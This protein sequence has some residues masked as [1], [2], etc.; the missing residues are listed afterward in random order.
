MKCDRCNAQIEPG[1]KKEYLGQILCEDCYMDAL[2]PPKGCDPWAV[3]AAKSFEKHSASPEAL[4]PI[5]KQILKILEET[6]GIEHQDLLQRL[7]DNLRPKDLERELSVLRHMEKV[8]G[9]KRG[10]R[11]V[12]RLW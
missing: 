6:G 12:C 8:R 5:Q 9:E 10:D 7:G 3:Y 1:E 4:T 2:S 11:V